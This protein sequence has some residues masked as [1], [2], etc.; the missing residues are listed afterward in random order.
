MNA[1][2]DTARPH[3]RTDA[4]NRRLLLLIA[5]IA[6]APVL[7]SYLTYYFPPRDARA[8][9]GTLLATT[10]LAAIT[11]KALPGEPFASADLR[12]RWTMLYDGAG[13][14]DTGC[15]DALFA[16][17]QARTIQNA[18]RE[19]VQRVWLIPD[20]QSP[21]QQVLDEHADLVIARVPRSATADLPEGT[22][23][24]YLIDPLGNFVLAWPSRPDIKA[25]AKDLARLL[26]ASRIG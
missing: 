19:R 8:N 10:P 24:I 20:E 1:G 14:C 21:P 26:R 12:G 9:Y 25:L 11:G 7:L 5:T 3:A 18:E 15:A 6:I 17:R 4:R 16:T 13:A 23:R 2:P 22:D